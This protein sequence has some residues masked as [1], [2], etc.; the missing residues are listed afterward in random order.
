MLPAFHPKNVQVV[1]FLSLDLGPIGIFQPLQSFGKLFYAEDVYTLNLKVN[2][3][4]RNTK[5]L[6]QASSEVGLELNTEKAYYMVM[7]SYQNL[8]QNYNLLISNKYFGN[9]TKFKY[10]GTTVTNQNCIHEEI[11]SRLNSVNA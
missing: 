8:G 2:I 6:L 4:K 1:I 9:V 5:S 11:K 7:S 10:F 3:V